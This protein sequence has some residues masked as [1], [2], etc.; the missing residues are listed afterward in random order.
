MNIR[1]PYL[2][3][4]LAADVI[5]EDKENIVPLHGGRPV[6]KLAQSLSG[7]RNYSIDYLKVKLQ[8]ERNQFETQLRDLEE[9][10]DPLQVYLNYIEWTHRNFPQGANT[11][12]GLFS[13]LERCASKFRDISL[14]KNDPRYL[15][16]WLEYIEYHDTPREAYI[17]LATKKIGIEL[18]LFYEEFARH[19]E[20]TGKFADAYGV[21]EIGT[22]HRAYP[23]TRLE[24]S[25]QRFKER[26]SARQ[27]SVA[28]PSEDIRHALT[29][30]QGHRIESGSEEQPLKRSKIDVFQ[31]NTES[32]LG[33]IKSAF[34]KESSLD[35]RL[36]SRKSRTKENTLAATRWSGQI[37]RQKKMG[38]AA[39]SEKLQV[40]CDNPT[41]NTQGEYER[42]Y[43]P[44][45]LLPNN[46]HV[47]TVI[48][49]V[50]KR[51]ERVMLNMDLLYSHLDLES[52][53]AE[54]LARSRRSVKREA[55]KLTNDSFIGRTKDDDM[56]T[57][58]F[59]L[60]TLENTSK[61][62]SKDPTVTMYSKMAKNEVF[63][64]FNQASQT[65]GNQGFDDTRLE[66]P[67]VTNFEG[68]VTETMPA[69][70]KKQ[71]SE[72]VIPT[73]VDEINIPTQAFDGISSP[74]KYL[75]SSKDG[76]SET[77]KITINPFDPLTKREI[78]QSLTIPLASY[79]G[80]F[81]KSSTSARQ[82]HK[83]LDAFNNSYSQYNP[84]SI[85]LDCLGDEMYS[86]VS[87]LRKKECSLVC[88]IES[89]SGCLKVLKISRPASSWEF[90]ILRRIRRRLLKDL[91]HEKQFVKAESLFRYDDESFLV[92]EYL[93]Q[94]NLRDVINLFKKK[95]KP[96]DECLAM[97]FSIRLL[98]AIE[99]LHGMD[100]IHAH[101]SPENC[102][103]NFVRCEDGNF[104]EVFD[105]RG[106]NGWDKK[107]LTLIDF[108]ASID[109]TGI[110][111][112]TSFSSC[113]QIFDSCF[114]KWMNGKTWTYEI[115][116]FGLANTIHT[117]LFD[118]CLEMTTVD[119]KVQIQRRLSRF[120][121][122]QM[123]QEVFEVLLN[124]NSKVGHQVNALE[125]KKV[126]GKLEA[127]LESYAEAGN[128]KRTIVSLEEDF[129]CD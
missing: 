45:E 16:V 52:S 119:G 55:P 75:P 10:D 68:F 122:P 57:G 30:K 105:R 61:L 78:L 5:E 72:P 18:S 17:Y 54:I 87:C 82:F 32:D 33:T 39:P 37:L 95:G 64:I 89:E 128:L 73:Q 4:N 84:H 26:M 79:P 34:E 113:G 2:T 50:G 35:L 120:W 38:L 114:V 90:F 31:D 94:G 6:T 91:S 125:L 60:P 110:Q 108:S 101:V 127:W 56:D 107:R 47:Y 116:Y 129:D 104:S 88:L 111:K 97:L 13:L 59:T 24:K 71:H 106:K 7:S 63:G 9:L 58:T 28:P 99:T 115:D 11:S 43:G 100:I 80:Y 96:L 74:R 83:I 41:K 93:P 62:A 49:V 81:E 27:I 92:L 29:L 98:E 109:L 123:W 121:Q 85:I 19:L 23:Y 103:I 51:P 3:P 70:K 15:R 14:Y 65:C 69:I 86:V 53:P 124:P 76:A 22:D 126:R 102:M 36:E 1:R 8:E 42:K 40:F 66:E 12:S 21:Y 44:I 25:F 112:G 20:L 48:E 117:L 67:T 118:E 46:Q 77:D